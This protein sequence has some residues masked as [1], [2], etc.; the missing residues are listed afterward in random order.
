MGRNGRPFRASSSISSVC[1]ELFL[2]G[3]VNVVECVRLDDSFLEQEMVEDFLTEKLIHKIFDFC[4]FE[5]D[6][7][8]PFCDCRFMVP[9]RWDLKCRTG[10]N[11]IPFI[12]A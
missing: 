9:Y 6:H 5:C 1:I 11:M 3:S 8:K 2:Y 4:Y 12:M 7:K 10:I